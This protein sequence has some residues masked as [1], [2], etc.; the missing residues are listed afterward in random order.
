MLLYLWFLDFFGW[1]LNCFFLPH[2]TT[3]NDPKVLSFQS[4]TFSFRSF[5]NTFSFF[6]SLQL[7]HAIFT[8]F[9]CVFVSG[10]SIFLGVNVEVWLLTGIYWGCKPKAYGFVSGFQAEGLLLSCPCEH[11]LFF[12]KI[13]YWEVSFLA[14]NGLAFKPN[15]DL[16][17][18]R[19][20]YKLKAQ[21]SVLR[22]E[23]NRLR[24]WTKLI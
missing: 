21:R 3:T 5:N 22:W 19:F 17:C 14:I 9:R 16:V 24:P 20:K 7:M 1:V 4:F 23:F 6:C 13:H 8:C 12:C 2:Y 10:G 15:R 11:Y 18:K